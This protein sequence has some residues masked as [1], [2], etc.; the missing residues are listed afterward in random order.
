MVADLANIPRI[1]TALAEWLSCLVFIIVGKTRFSIPKLAIISLF[2]LVAQSTFL[3]VTEEALGVMWVVYMALAVLLMFLFIYSTCSVTLAAAG[4]YTIHAFV[5]AEFTASL[6]W[7]I[8]SYL[9]PNKVTPDL[10]T[11][12]LLIG[13]YATIY[14]GSWLAI[15]RYT[16]RSSVLNV[17]SS[18]LLSAYIIGISVFAISN[19]SYLTTKTPFS[20]QFAREIFNIR[21]ITGLCGILLLGTY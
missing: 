15:K 13:V 6:E 5:L 8:H 7:Q 10:S 18:H 12:L 14:A 9:W 1:Y 3:V 20:G 16:Q 2:F 17:E 4:Y 21:T 19:L 11:V